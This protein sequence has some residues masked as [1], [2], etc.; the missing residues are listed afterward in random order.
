[1]NDTFVGKKDVRVVSF[2]DIGTPVSLLSG[3]YH[4]L[5]AP[6]NRNTTSM[7]NLQSSTPMDGMIKSIKDQNPMRP[8]VRGNYSPDLDIPVS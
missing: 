7:P 4:F 6:Q 5:D 3:G 1:M 2:N 8:T